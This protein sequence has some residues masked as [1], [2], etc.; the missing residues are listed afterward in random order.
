ML[1]Q[2]LRK[3]HR[4]DILKQL[5][6]GKFEKQEEALKEELFDLAEECYNRVYDKKTIDQMESLPD[7]WLHL[8]N[9]V[10]VRFGEKERYYDHIKLRENKRFLSKH[11]Y[12]C[13]LVLDDQDPLFDKYEKIRDKKSE[14]SEKRNKI[15]AEVNSILNSHNTTLQLIKSWPEIESIVHQVCGEV[16]KNKA[17]Y[18][19]PATVIDS[20][21]EQLGL[22]PENEA[23]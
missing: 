20:L 15:R 23:E 4:E 11:R 13:H 18:H 7:G 12:S 9:D 21:N 10:S 5:L 8:N 19:V 17:K 14:L 1:S 22:P 6:K 16:V 2:P 3:H